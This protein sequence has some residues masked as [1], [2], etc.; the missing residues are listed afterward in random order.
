VG[1]LAA[2]VGHHQVAGLRVW[3]HGLSDWATWPTVRLQAGSA[4][5]MHSEM[6]LFLQAASA[7]RPPAAR[8]ARAPG[9]LRPCR[10]YLTQLNYLI[11]FAPHRNLEMKKS[12]GW[13][14]TVI[15]VAGQGSCRKCTCLSVRAGLGS[16][17]V[18]Y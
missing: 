10:S 6:S 8:A 4:E 12:T 14:T 3:V 11:A 18:Y 2:Q 15:H 1:R 7:C 13:R 9:D 17:V 16:C 5:R